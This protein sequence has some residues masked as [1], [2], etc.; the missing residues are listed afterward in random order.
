MR[1]GQTPI[2]RLPGTRRILMLGDSYLFGAGVRVDEALPAALE[3][4]LNRETPNYVWEVLNLAR[5]GASLADQLGHFRRFLDAVGP[6]YAAEH[7]VVLVNYTDAEPQPLRMNFPTDSGYIES[8]WQ[9]S[10]A[11]RRFLAHCV[12]ELRDTCAMIGADLTLLHFDHLRLAVSAAGLRLLREIESETGVDVI[13]LTPA[14]AKFPPVALRVSEIDE[15]PNALAH[16][17]AAELL[18]ARLAGRLECADQPVNQWN[19][20]RCAALAMPLSSAGA[21]YVERMLG[22]RGLSGEWAG[23]PPGRTAI[24]NETL[25]AAGRH[26]ASV[27]ARVRPFDGKLEFAMQQIELSLAAIASGGKL[28]EEPVV[29]RRWSAMLPPNICR[30]DFSIEQV[31]HLVRRFESAL[32]CDAD[33]IAALQAVLASF[34]QY[35]R[36]AGQYRALECERLPDA[37]A[38]AVEDVRR[39]MALVEQA[40]QALAVEMRIPELVGFL[41]APSIAREIVLRLRLRTQCDVPRSILV[42]WQPVVPLRPLAR[43]GCVIAESGREW[44]VA[45][46]LPLVGEAQLSFGGELDGVECKS[47][48]LRIGENRFALDPMRAFVPRRRWRIVP[49]LM[50]AEEVVLPSASPAWTAL[51]ALWP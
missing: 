12:A 8:T 7:V 40:L 49:G 50:L 13:D 19:A 5:R 37:V 9:P 31:E 22:H 36:L 3:S 38:Q 23:E 24:L 35:V 10:A 30:C 32:T 44:A 46:H 25:V 27:I 1:A 15:H 29:Q 41:A 43:E 2:G 47:I 42:N 14:F 4:R 18:A 16:R 26:F 28:A 21:A 39:G 51:A 33:A 11:T 45:L 20:W 17:V 6:G 34:R 48:E